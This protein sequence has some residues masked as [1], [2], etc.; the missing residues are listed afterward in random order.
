[1]S[2]NEISRYSKLQKV[3]ESRQMMAQVALNL[4][5][6]LRQ[7]KRLKLESELCV[8]V[9]GVLV[10]DAPFESERCSAV[11][12]QGKTEGSAPAVVANDRF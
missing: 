10:K 2:D 3:H 4:G 6:S 11:V 5:L 9:E 1:M 8:D 12:D 7:V